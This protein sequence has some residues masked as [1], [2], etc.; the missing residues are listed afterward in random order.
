M[1]LKQLLFIAVLALAGCKRHPP[2]IGGDGGAPT[3]PLDPAAEAKARADLL[4][5]VDTWRRTAPKKRDF[6]AVLNP[7]MEL[8]QG[9]PEEPVPSNAGLLTVVQEAPATGLAA[10]SPIIV[11]AVQARLRA[12]LR[13]EPTDDEVIEQITTVESQ[14][15]AD[16]SEVLLGHHEEIAALHREIAA[17]NQQG[18]TDEVRQRQ[19]ALRSIR[20]GVLATWEQQHGVAAGKVDVGAE[21]VTPEQA[22]AANRALLFTWLNDAGTNAK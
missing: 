20:A 13:R 5:A 16:I 7:R 10:Y 9:D 11:R 4:A 12:S 2:L 8:L 14:Q 21:A 1:T 17:L 6:L 19:R 22:A 3:S 15:N 18:K